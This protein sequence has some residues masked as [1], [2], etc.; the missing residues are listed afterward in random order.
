MNKIININHKNT[1]NIRYLIFFIIFCLTGCS[2]FRKD[3]INFSIKADKNLN[4]NIHNKPSP[5][6]ISLYQLSSDEDFRKASLDALC[7]D[8][9]MFEDDI[10]S[11]KEIQLRPRQILKI[12]EPLLPE[13]K[14]IGIVAE[15]R[16]PKKNGWKEIIDFDDITPSKVKIDVEKS[17][18]KIKIN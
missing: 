6:V 10:L 8:P 4:L 12:R 1:L 5:L 11:K 15:F 7:H 9:G 18:M 16:N 17:R 3:N 2:Y 13:T 14:Y